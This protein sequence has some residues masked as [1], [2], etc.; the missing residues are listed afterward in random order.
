MRSKIF[1]SKAYQVFDYICRLIILNILL[2]GCSFSIFLI[3]T[4]IFKDLK[5][6][7]QLLLFIPSALTLMP[8]ILSVFGVIKSYEIEGTTGILKEYFRCFKKYYFKSL[9]LS[10]ILIVYIILMG[11]SY[12]YFDSMK[13]SGIGYLVGY[14]L[15]ISF[16]LI[17]IICFIH[18]PL[19]MIYFDDLKL[20][21]YI[22]LSFI[23]AF[24]DLGL[25]ICLTILLVISIILSYYFNLYLLLISF[26]LTIFLIVKLT[27]SKYLKISERNKNY[28]E[29]ND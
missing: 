22:K 3:I 14:L 10:V 27:K 16:I 13:T 26:S 21:H 19:T 5:E 29:N 15:T 12:A 18:L 4:N 20:K 17:S 9:L 25:T 28:E 7:Y 11:N 1:N 2:I 8:S 23:F 6:I 24:K